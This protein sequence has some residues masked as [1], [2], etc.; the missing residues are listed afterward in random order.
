MEPND[1]DGGILARRIFLL[2][3]T[4]VCAVIVAMAISWASL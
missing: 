4:G 3:V 2:S 1:H